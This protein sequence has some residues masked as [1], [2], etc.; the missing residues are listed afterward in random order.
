MSTSTLE[1][2]AHDAL[3]A[4]L[5]L[6]KEL[7]AQFLS[8]KAQT[9]KTIA[10]LQANGP[11]GLLK[12]AETTLN[13][14]RAQIEKSFEELAARGAADQSEQVVQLRSLLDQG[15]G[16]VKDIQSKVEGTLQN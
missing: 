10:D 7:E 16:A 12:S 3:N 2:T 6:F 1:T 5:G 14:L 9:E 8:L 15:I 4:G 11:E 13:D